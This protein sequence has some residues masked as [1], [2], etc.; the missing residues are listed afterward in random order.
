MDLILNFIG[1]NYLE[2]NQRDDKG[3]VQRRFDQEEPLSVLL[4][5]VRK[6]LATRWYL[7]NYKVSKVVISADHS[8]DTKQASLKKTSRFQFIGYR[9]E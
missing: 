7:C 1:F 4:L 5:S 9:L 8:T 6:H 3:G 2:E